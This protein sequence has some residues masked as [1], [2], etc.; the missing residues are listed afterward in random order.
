MKNNDKKIVSLG[1]RIYLF[2]NAL[3]AAV[4]LLVLLWLPTD[5]KN[6]LLIGY[7]KNRLALIGALFFLSIFF[8]YFGV[9][10]YLNPRFN[11]VLLQRVEDFVREYRSILL[12]MLPLFGFTFLVLFGYFNDWIRYQAI[13]SFQVLFARLLPLIL[14]G[15]SL[16]LLTFLLVI[17]SR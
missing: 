6:A 17:L 7:S 15:F 5:Q 11:Q 16:V 3:I 2:A 10:S 4:C 13:T 12:V 9:K 8:V 1:V 14:F